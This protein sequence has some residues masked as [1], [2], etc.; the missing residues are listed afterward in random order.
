M[1]ASA[2]VPQ[3]LLSVWPGLPS[4]WRGKASGLVLAL[5]FSWCVG[6]GLI[7][8]LVWPE[9][10]RPGAH[11]M[12]WLVVVG[13][14]I[15]TALPHVIRSVS[16]RPVLAEVDSL[17]LFC[18]AQAEYLRGDLQQTERLLLRLLKF[19]PDDV[20]ARMMLATLYRHQ[21][22]IRRSREQLDQ[23]A[24]SPEGAKW[25]MEIAREL[26]MVQRCEEDKT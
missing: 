2:R 19:D 8:S 9:W 25:K 10:F 7:L 18:H 3:I 5:V 11:A 1:A 4:L 12:V 26:Q 15:V 16:G 22:D 21:R 23:V 13:T 6:V 20:D 14:W 24:R 17:G